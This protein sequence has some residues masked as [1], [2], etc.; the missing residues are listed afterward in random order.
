MNFP[1]NDHRQ[2]YEHDP[3][4]ATPPNDPNRWLKF[5]AIFLFCGWGISLLVL[6]WPEAPRQF[7]SEFLSPTST[8]T[9][10]FDSSTPPGVFIGPKQNANSRSFPT[11]A[12]RAP[13]TPPAVTSSHSVSPPAPERAAHPLWAI[14]AD[15]QKIIDGIN[16]AREARGLRAYAISNCLMAAADA[17]AQDMVDNSYFSHT[18]PA[19]QHSNYF[20]AQA[21]YHYRFVGE[22][23]ARG[24]DTID[25][26]LLAWYASPTHLAN[27]LDTDFQDTGV[28]IRGSLLVQLFAVGDSNCQ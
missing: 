5:F 3:V 4:Y 28:A 25:N 16:G 14:S 22:N 6:F 18:S 8:I 7:D 24:Y 9:L 20:I 15:E 10:P 19:G 17:R 12:Q 26:A 23:L 13:G 1:P 27:I 11:S 21:G 2:T